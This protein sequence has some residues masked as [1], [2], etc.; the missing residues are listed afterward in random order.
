VRAQ[1]EGGIVFGLSAALQGEITLQAGR[2]RQDSLDAYRLLTL[3]EAPEIDVSVIAGGD[4]P[5]GV[6]EAGVPAVA[7]ALCNAIL[8]A[9]GRPVARLPVRL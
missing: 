6:G 2:V 9:T 7:P 5:A 8:A 4:R 1:I 3:D